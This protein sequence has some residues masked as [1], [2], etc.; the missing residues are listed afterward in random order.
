[1]LLMDTL[2]PH[3]RSARMALVRGRDTK[4]EMVVRRLVHGMGFR[5]RLHSA[6]LPGKPDLVFTKKCKI[7][8]VH[9]CFW[10]RHRGCSRCRLPKSRLE[11]WKPKLEANRERDVEVQTVLRQAGWSVLIVW[12]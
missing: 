4:P 11:F 1:M 3:E 8:F 6:D 7:I 9:G 2:S 5:Y 12:E 10:H